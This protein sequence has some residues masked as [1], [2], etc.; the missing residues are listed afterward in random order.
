MIQFAPDE[1]HWRHVA[2]VLRR[3]IADGTY[4]PCTRVPSAVQLHASS[5]LPERRA[6]K[7]HRALRGEGLIYTEP[8]LGA[9]VAKS[10]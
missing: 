2:A 3:R 1:P 5:T 4:P 6:R 7:V 8:G 9:L 10:R